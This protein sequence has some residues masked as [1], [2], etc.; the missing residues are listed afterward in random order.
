MSRKVFSILVM[1]AVISLLIISAIIIV[2][3]IYTHRAKDKKAAQPP[4]ANIKNKVAYERVENFKVPI[5]MYHYIRDAENEDQLGQNLSVSPITFDNQM[6]WLKEND[7]A[8]I[9]L[10]DLA[11]EERIALSKVYGEGKK[12]VVLTFDDGYTDA[13]TNALPILKKY[14]F[15][16]TFFIITAYTEKKSGYLTQ[17]QIDE[18]KKA[19]MEIGSHTLTHPDLTKLDYTNARDQIFISKDDALVFCYP[20]GKYDA[21]AEKLVKSAGYV[22]AVTT[23]SG[24]ATEKSDLFLLPRLRIE[25]VS[26]AVFAKKFL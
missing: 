5:L 23:K 18:M 13:Y 8:T 9:Q 22:A 25:D 19:G 11:D 20:A 26:L 15:S 21:Q 1:V 17:S 16:G 4:T 24:I 2:W 7:Y 6:K 3:S 14:D 10:A 12:P